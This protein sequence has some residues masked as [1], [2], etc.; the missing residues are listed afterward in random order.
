MIKAKSLVRDKGAIYP[1]GRKRVWKVLQVKYAIQESNPLAARGYSIRFR[2]SPWRFKAQAEK[3]LLH[4]RSKP[5]Y[6]VSVVA[7]A[8]LDRASFDHVDGAKR[9]KNLGNEW[10]PLWELEEVPETDPGMRK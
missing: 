6:R 9:G 7:V 2:Q 4:Y 5:G 8:F 3:A 1:L 10:T